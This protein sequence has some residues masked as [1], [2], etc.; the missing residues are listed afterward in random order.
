MNQPNQAA[1]DHNPQALAAAADNYRLL[2]DRW[3]DSKTCGADLDDNEGEYVAYY[4]DPESGSHGWMCCN[5]NCIVQT[6]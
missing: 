1:G 3:H 5:C 6:G 4:R 2:I